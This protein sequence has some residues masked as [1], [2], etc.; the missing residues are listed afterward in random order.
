MCISNISLVF[1]Y[2]YHTVVRSSAVE[3]WQKSTKSNFSFIFYNRKNLQIL[4]TMMLW[5]PS[6]TNYATKVGLILVGDKIQKAIP[7]ICKYLWVCKK[8]SMK[9]MK[10][11]FNQ[12]TVNS[13]NAKCKSNTFFNKAGRLNLLGEKFC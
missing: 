11:T 5:S 3:D 10:Y 2:I 7:D 8:F 12:A 6:T 9:Y 13:W 4:K 1:L